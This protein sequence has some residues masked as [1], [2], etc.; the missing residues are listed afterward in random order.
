MSEKKTILVISDHPLAPSGVGIQ[1]KYFIETL[2]L[3]GKYRFICL[4][5]AVKHPNYDPQHITDERSE[6][7]DWV[8]HPVD[9]YGNAETIRSILWTAKPD[10]FWFLT[11]QRFYDWLWAF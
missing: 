7:G 9:G 8:V 1:T 2:I 6:D 11:D 10:L 3:T 5:G 4:C